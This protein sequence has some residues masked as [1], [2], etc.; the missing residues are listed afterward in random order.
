M[1]K[2][3]HI[4]RFARP[5]GFTLLELL[6]VLGILALLTAIVYPRVTRYMGT[7]RT[8]AARAQ[9]GAL[10]TA[11]ELYALDNGTYPA[12]SEGLA[13]LVE[14]PASARRWNGPYIKRGS[15]LLD[16]WGNPYQYNRPGRSGPFEVFTL[17]RDNKPGGEA[18]D[19]DLAGG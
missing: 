14:K 15:G 1:F 11:V 16:P 5:D 2:G 12:T 10:V 13:A 6:V 4:H 3:R 19:Q 7:A 9:I 18:E 17:G 8:E